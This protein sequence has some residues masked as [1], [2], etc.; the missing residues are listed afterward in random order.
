M[1]ELSL[2]PLR[3]VLFPGRIRALRV[4]HRLYRELVQRHLEERRP[5][6]VVWEGR[7]RSGRGGWAGTQARIVEVERG[8]EA[9]DVTL[10]G[11][12]RLWIEALDPTPLPRG[13][14]ERWPLQV[15]LPA[16]AQ[17]IWILHRELVRLLP[18]Y[19]LR[20]GRLLDPRIL[21]RMDP[22]ALALTAAELIRI[23]SRER[24]AL[25]EAPTLGQLM[26]D[27]VRLLREGLLL[28]RLLGLEAGPG[29]RPPAILRPLPRPWRPP[30]PS[31][32]NDPASS[33][34]GATNLTL[35]RAPIGGIVAA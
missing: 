28:D 24:Q 16:E 13:W 26:A 29:P 30:G 21:V 12:A 17:Q 18:P 6:A 3:D 9:W 7:I 22:L 33:P 20:Q 23:P 31:G 8:E 34:K 27:L 11:E 15:G 2:V 35:T 14:G 1:A 19:A 32:R 4:R 25:L 5:L 10:I